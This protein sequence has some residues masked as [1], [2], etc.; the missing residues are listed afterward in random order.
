MLPWIL[1][2]LIV[3]PIAEVAVFVEVGARW[4]LWPTVGTIFATAIAG[5]ILVYHQGVAVLRE[6]RNELAAGQ[7]PARR[8]FDGSCLLIAGALLLLP[9]FMTDA[10]GLLL[11]LPM[12]RRLFL[13]GLTNRIQM[14]SSGVSEAHA[15]SGGQTIDAEFAD[16][17]DQS[18][19]LTRSDQQLP[20]SR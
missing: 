11:F 19:P 1:T 3:T 5:S 15:H 7:F 8:I 9:G 16:V 6:V 20:S 10:V 17:T 4:G 13:A 2:T 18:S 12:V 14:Q